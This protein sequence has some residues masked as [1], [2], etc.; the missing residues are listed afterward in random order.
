M[1]N[2]GE[3]MIEGEREHKYR[4]QNGETPSY[5]AFH[6]VYITKD[7]GSERNEELVAFINKN[8]A[9]L[10]GHIEDKHGI[11][12]MLFERKQDAQTFSNELSAR[13]NIQKEHITIK[14]RKYTR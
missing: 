5:K 8:V 13:L 11:P 6:E 12:L 7:L 1:N 14:A 4:S 3:N 9:K 2:K 10:K